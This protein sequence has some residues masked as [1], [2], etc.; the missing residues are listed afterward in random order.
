MDHQERSTRYFT[1]AR[2]VRTHGNR[3]EL[4][5]ELEAEPQVWGTLPEAELWDPAGGRRPA[6][7]RGFRPHGKR[8]ILAFEGITTLS[9]AEQVAGGEVRIPASARPP[10]PPG[11][12]YVAD[13]VGCEVVD[14]GSGRSLGWVRGWLETGAVPL[15]EVS[16][17]QREISIPFA[18]AICVEVDPAGRTIRVR[19]PEGLE[20]LNR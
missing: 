6:R 11:R 15:L 19:L 18:A 8:W 16:D 9:E 13:L 3:G 17:G 10:V 4:A 20:D 14:A 7:L 2:L 5:A 12:H 1:V